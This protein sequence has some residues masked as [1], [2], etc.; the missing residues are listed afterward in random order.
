MYIPGLDEKL[1]DVKRHFHRLKVMELAITWA[2]R[3]QMLHW[4]RQ[5]TWPKQKPDPMGQSRFDHQ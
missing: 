5:D 4:K 2:D 3:L 1:R